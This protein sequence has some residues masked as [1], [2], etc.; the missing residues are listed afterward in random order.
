M[1][2]NVKSRDAFPAIAA[3][4]PW[5]SVPLAELSQSKCLLDQLLLERPTAHGSFDVKPMLQLQNL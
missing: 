1:E 3:M 4:A 5:S 2:I